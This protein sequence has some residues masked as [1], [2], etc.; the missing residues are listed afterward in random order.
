MVRTIGLSLAVLFVGC[1][2][3]QEPAPVGAETSVGNIELSFDDGTDSRSLER[4]SAE[5]V[6]AAEPGIVVPYPLD[7]IIGTFSDCRGGGRTHAGLDIAGSGE[8]LGLGERIYALA[9]SEITMIGRPEEDADRFG[10]PDLRDG[11]TDRDDVELP[12]SE[13]IS[14]YGEVNFFTRTYGSWH[15]GAILVTVVTDGP[16]ASS[17]HAPWRDSPRAAGWRRR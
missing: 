14:G 12:R 7:H 8:L 5:V 13:V 2:G 3:R 4:S 11:T 9:R 16:Y 17:V 15:S 10:R 6:S 1:S